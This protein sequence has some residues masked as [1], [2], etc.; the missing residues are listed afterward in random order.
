MAGWRDDELAKL[1][2]VEEIQIAPRRRDGSMGQP[3]IVWAVRHGDGVYVRSAVRGRNA[4]WFRSVKDSHQGRIRAAGLDKDVTFEVA[5]DDINAG[6]DAAYRA[7][8]RRYAG[9]ILDSVLTS[10]ARSTTI[11][12]VPDST[13]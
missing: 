4:A 3:V 10:E 1:A 13:S 6:V 2:G 11:R 5:H 7:K 8:Y 12:I 9:R